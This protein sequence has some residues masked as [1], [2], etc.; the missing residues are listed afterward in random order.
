MIILKNIPL[1]ALRDFIQ[2]C[3]E[4]LWKNIAE[5]KSFLWVV[6]ALEKWLPKS[7]EHGDLW[8]NIMRGCI[9]VAW[10]L[11]RNGMQLALVL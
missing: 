5:T 9:D 11:W 3:N 1:F 6:L 10:S 4:Q 2:H 8:R 7:G